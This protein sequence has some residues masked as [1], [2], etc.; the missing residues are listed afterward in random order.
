MRSP[1][2]WRSR[3]R[4][5]RGTWPS[6]AVTPTPGTEPGRWRVL[7]LPQASPWCGGLS[8][9]PGAGGSALAVAGEVAEDDLVEALLGDQVLAEQRLRSHVV[10]LRRR[11]QRSR[12]LHL[13]W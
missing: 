10:Q 1:S 6:A 8:M 2:R 5:S 11:A 7:A 9:D 13:R 4:W 3:W 12:G